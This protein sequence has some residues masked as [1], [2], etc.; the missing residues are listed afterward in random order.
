[1]AVTFDA[2]STGYNTSVSSLTV[3]HTCSGSNR[4]LTVSCL[5]DQ[6]VSITGIT[7]NGVA[8][9]NIL[10][11][12]NV[13]LLQKLGLYYLVAPS[14]GANNIVVSLSGSAASVSVSNASYTGVKQSSAID[15][16]NSTTG[17]SASPSV[18]TTTTVNNSQVICAIGWNNSVANTSPT[19]SITA[20]ASIDDSFLGTSNWIGDKATTTAGSYTGGYTASSSRQYAIG[21]FGI[22]EEPVTPNPAFISNFV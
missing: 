21:I 12:Q 4:I 17:S 9:T 1:M 3:S 8:M 16:S 13:V 19:N 6:T 5:F 11:A 22:K 10:T 14:T 20:R 7:Y 18:S 15:S 2:Q